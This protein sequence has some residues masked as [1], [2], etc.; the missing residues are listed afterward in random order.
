MATPIGVNWLAVWADDVWG[1]VWATTF[2]DFSAYRLTRY[3]GEH[4]AVERKSSDLGLQR[5]SGSHLT[6]TRE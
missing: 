6:L 5:H 1:P 2:A 3:S 4:F